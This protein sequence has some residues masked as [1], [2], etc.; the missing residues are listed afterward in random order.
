MQGAEAIS[1][2]I[3][4][5]LS[6]A[7]KGS[8]LSLH[9]GWHWLKSSHCNCRERNAEGDYHLRARHRIRHLQ[10]HATALCP[11][12]CCQEGCLHQ[13]LKP[14]PTASTSTIFAEWLRSRSPADSLAIWK[15]QSLQVR[16]CCTLICLVWEKYP[17]LLEHPLGWGK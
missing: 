14:A 10:D 9:R 6:R 5:P 17:Q 12:T 8:C 3:P 4:R 11:A 7:S 1:C 15:G 16:D 13:S 2:A